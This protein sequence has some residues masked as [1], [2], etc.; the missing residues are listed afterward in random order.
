MPYLKVIQS[1]TLIE[2]YE[3]E[4][5]PSPARLVGRQPRRKRIIPQE[6]RPDA[7]IRCRNAFRRLVRA[8]LTPES[9]PALLTLT[10]RD[11]EID[12]SDAY[13]LY[14]VFVQRFRRKYGKEVAM[15][16]VPEFQK[17]GAVHFHILVFNLPYETYKNERSTR[18]IASLWGGGFVDIKRT[19]G[20]EKLASYLAKY[21]SKA[22]SDY[23][24]IRKRAYSATRNVLR[25]VSFNTPFQTKLALELL[26]LSPDSSPLQ[27]REYATMWLGRCVYKQYQMK[28]EGSN[29]VKEDNHL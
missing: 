24:L 8:N 28:Y 20:S 3:Y 26:E 6:R 1:G 9:P 19:D 17:R 10:L 11:K 23:R 2:T 15:I 14:T 27:E 25:S 4:R 22:M 12:I 7:I 16:G 29:H 5:P 21:M 18:A 13:K